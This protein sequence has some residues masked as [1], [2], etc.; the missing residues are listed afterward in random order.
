MDI[1]VNREIRDYTESIFFG[2]SLRQFFFSALACI[3]AVVVYFLLKPIVGTEIVSW[4]CILVSMPLAGLGFIKYNG[5]PA[6]KIVLAWIKS[7]ILM[8]KHLVWGNTNKYCLMLS[9]IE[10]KTKKKG[11]AIFVKNTKSNN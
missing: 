11:V 4:L 8:P 7:E 9:E 3:C 1:K 10:N 2:L 5:M 6:E